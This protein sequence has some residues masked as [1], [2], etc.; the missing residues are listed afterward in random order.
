LI[1]GTLYVTELLNKIRPNMGRKEAEKAVMNSALDTN[2]A[3]PGDAGFPLNQMFEPPRER[4]E[5][6]VLRQYVMQMRQE[7][8]VRLLGRV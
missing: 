8:A 3:I 7:L 1:Y 4:N 6:E 5:A 2:F